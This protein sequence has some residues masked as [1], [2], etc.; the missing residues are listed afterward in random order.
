MFG[1]N[2]ISCIG[3]LI[4]GVQLCFHLAVEIR[5]QNV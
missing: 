4:A 2:D 5:E 3:C 1:T